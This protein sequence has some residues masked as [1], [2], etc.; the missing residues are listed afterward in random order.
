MIKLF[1][2]SEEEKN[3]LFK[4]EISKTKNHEKFPGLVLIKKENM[5]CLT[6]WKPLLLNQDSLD[7]LVNLKNI[8]IVLF[9]GG[10]FCACFFDKKQLVVS[11]S[12]H[13]YIIRKKQGKKQSTND[14]GGHAQSA[15]S[16]IRRENEKNLMEDVKE[17][18]DSWEKYFKQSELILVQIPDIKNRKLVLGELEHDNRVQ[19]IPFTLPKANMDN[20]KLAFEKITKIKL[21]IDDFDVEEMIEPL[22]P[23]NEIEIKPKFF[24]GDLIP[25][26]ITP[27]DKNDFDKFF[28]EKVKEMHFKE[29]QN[30]P[31]IEKKVIKRIEKPQTNNGYFRFFLFILVIGL[32]GYFLIN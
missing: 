7:H 2:I 28:T 27:I 31:I 14:K 15:G 12:F 21:S 18:R 32:M 22:T 1:E 10:D 5:D 30:N 24:Q 9:H 20:S 13:K 25:T 8:L 16:Q 6:I 19:N 11:K 23:I 29:I 4:G 3:K 17:W 26:P